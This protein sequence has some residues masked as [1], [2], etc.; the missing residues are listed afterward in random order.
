M[1]LRSERLYSTLLFVIALIDI[2]N[3]NVHFGVADN[4]KVRRTGNFPTTAVHGDSNLGG[5]IGP[6]ITKLAGNQKIQGAAI[7]SVVPAATAAVLAAVA[8]S[9]DVNPIQLTPATVRGIGINYPKPGTI[10]QDRLAN[11]I[12]VHHHFGAPSVVV[13]FGTAVTFDIVDR[14][15]DYVGGIIAPGLAVMTDYMHEKTALL[16]RIKFRDPG[17]AIGKNTTEA[18]LVGAVHGFRGLV[19]ELIR[20]V[21]GELK[22]RNLPVVATGSY[23]SLIASGVKEITQVSPSLTLEGLRLLWLAHNS[24]R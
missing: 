15:G 24:G 3:T 1:H 9:L 6:A 19:R 2:G 20:E 22:A 16:P 18:M 10:G 11:A 17:V 14:A 13:D 4:G 5:G 7:C 12:A 23:A 8:D 21:K